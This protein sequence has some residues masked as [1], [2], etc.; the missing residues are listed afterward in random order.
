MN[1]IRLLAVGIIV[2]S[3]S[4]VGIRASL[5]HKARVVSDTI[6]RQAPELGNQAHLLL[7]DLDEAVMVV[8]DRP[9]D[10][11]E[12][13]AEDRFERLTRLRT[14]TVSTN[15]DGLRGPELGEKQGTRI[16]CVGDS[17]TFGWGVPY[18]ETYP[19]QLAKRL[20]VEVINAGVPAMKPDSIAKWVEQNAAALR[21]DL[22]L[23]ARRPDWGSPDPWG[24]YQ[25]SVR[26]VAAAVSPAKV[27]VLLPPVSTFD[28]MGV[29]NMDEE[30][31]RAEQLVRPLPV[32]DLTPAFREALPLP[33]V[34]LEI[35]DGTQRMVSLPART[36]IVEAKAPAGGPGQST[37]AAEIVAVFEADTSIVEP[38]F[39]DGG[40]P[41]AAGFVLFTDAVAAWIEAEGL[42]RAAPQGGGAPQ[43]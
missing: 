27:G 23:F 7:P 43:N 13:T 22:V 2:L 24:V 25:R 4:A 30:R 20:G 19:A 10:P 14:F 37:L 34:I 9:H 21:P 16:L 1:R 38:L 33:G 35:Q 42:L 39:F 36:T 31:R 15:A 12:V 6:T 17:V 41:D 5:R 40:H 29:A 3:V 8:A 32:L 18:A 11:F 28:P 26:A